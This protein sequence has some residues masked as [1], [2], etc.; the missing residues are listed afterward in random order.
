MACLEVVVSLEAG[1]NLEGPLPLVGGEPLGKASPLTASLA[2][3]GIPRV[4]IRLPDFASV[5]AVLVSCVAEFLVLVLAL[6][7]DDAEERLRREVVKV[8]FKLLD[9]V[10]LVSQE[11]V[12]GRGVRERRR[13]ARV[14]TALGTAEVLVVGGHGG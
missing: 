6:L 7:P 3:G 9:G 4:S 14:S 1:A 8:I 12:V 11:L 10:V 13:E 2:S 5:A